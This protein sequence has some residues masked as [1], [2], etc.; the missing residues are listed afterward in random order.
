MPVRYFAEGIKFAPP[1]PRKT[2]RWLQRIA[3]REGLEIDS[4]NFVFCSDSYLLRLNKKYKAHTTLTDILTFPYDDMGGLSADIFISVPRVRQNASRYG[5]AFEEE[6]HR[7]MVHGIL[8]LAGYGDLTVP[9]R[10]KMRRKE[11]QSLSLR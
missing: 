8:H 11:A 1:H 3:L 10:A 9:Q 7:V 6:L 2:S 5:V 4:L